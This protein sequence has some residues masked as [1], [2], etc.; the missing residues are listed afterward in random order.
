[1][2]DTQGLG[3]EAGG[4]LLRVELMKLPFSHLKRQNAILVNERMNGA[5]PFDTLRR[6]ETFHKKPSR[7]LDTFQYFAIRFVKFAY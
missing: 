6:N 4:T 2:T 3:S 7:T 5:F 1:V